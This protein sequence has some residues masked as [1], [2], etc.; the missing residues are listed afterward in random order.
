MCYLCLRNQLLPMCPVRTIGV[1][2]PEGLEPPA[3]WFEAENLRN[4]RS[5]QMRTRLASVCVLLLVIKE[6]VGLS[7][8]R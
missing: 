7:D 8:W 5:L 1:V 2:R 4:V 3:Y 6:F